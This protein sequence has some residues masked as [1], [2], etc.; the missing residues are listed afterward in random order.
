M[1]VLLA[2]DLSYCYYASFDLEALD[3]TVTCKKCDIELNNVK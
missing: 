3:S 2:G 1:S